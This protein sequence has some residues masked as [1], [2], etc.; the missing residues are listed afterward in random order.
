MKD[1]TIQDIRKV[2]QGR[3][4]CAFERVWTTYFENNPEDHYERS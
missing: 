2:A 1:L 4:I 3:Y